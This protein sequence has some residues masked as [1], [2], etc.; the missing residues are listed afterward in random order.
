MRPT[1]LERARDERDR[2]RDGIGGP[3]RSVVRRAL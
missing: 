2:G 3:K 1:L